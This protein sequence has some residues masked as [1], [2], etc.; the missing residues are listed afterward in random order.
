MAPRC[1]N[2]N[3]FFDE[4]VGLVFFK[5]KEKLS[6]N[7]SHISGFQNIALTNSSHGLNEAS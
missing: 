7:L 5:L 4:A 3:P 6:S 2:A 1:V